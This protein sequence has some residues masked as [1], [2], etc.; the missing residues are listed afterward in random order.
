MALPALACVCGGYCW[1]ENCCCY[2]LILLIWAKGWIFW[3]WH[4]GGDW[5]FCIWTGIYLEEPG[6]DW[7]WECKLSCLTRDPLG[8]NILWTL[9]LCWLV[10]SSWEI[11][12]LISTSFSCFMNPSFGFA[13]TL[14][15]TTNFRV[16]FNVHLY[17]HIKYE[18][19]IAELLDTPAKQCTNTLV[20]FLHDIRATCVVRWN[21]CSCWHVMKC[22]NLLYRDR[23]RP[24][25]K[26]CLRM[27]SLYLCYVRHTCLCWGCYH[28]S[29]SV[30]LQNSSILSAIHIS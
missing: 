26:E 20:N 12:S 7:D 29:Y 2:I 17:F 1:G 30:L 25:G 21:E 24:Y 11:F 8:L 28:G 27:S 23:Q 14:L 9:F 22:S 10:F 13:T 6:L 4:K 5:G 15:N 19:T 18:H 16:L 3:G